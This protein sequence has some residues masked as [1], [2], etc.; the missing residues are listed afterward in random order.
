MSKTTVSWIMSNTGTISLYLNGEIYSVRS[1]H[2]NY[3]K[4]VQALKTKSYSV[5]PDLINVANAV[6]KHAERCRLSGETGVSVANGQVLYNGEVV[7][8]Y[9]ADKIVDFV[10]DGFDFAP[11]TKFLGNLMANPSKKSVDNLYRFLE[12]NDMPITEDG[13]FLAYKRVR[14]DYK[15]MYEGKFDN[16][17]GQTVKMPRNKV[18]DDP[19]ITCSHGLHVAS[20]RYARDE[21]NSGQGRLVICK[22]NP[23]DVVSVPTDYANAKMRV[24][25]YEVVQDYTEEIKQ[26]SILPRMV[27]LETATHSDFDPYDTA[28][29]DEV[30]PNCG[31]DQDDCNCDDSEACEECGYPLDECDCEE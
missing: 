18:E 5:L 14:D 28:D 27:E 15:D 6:V 16:S 11:L 2:V 26:G 22:V 31:E 9:V 17:V 30:C 7:H 19:S 12:S 10:R 23:K 29:E 24:C 8:D 1:D 4:V 3:D 21:Y 20:L 13:C 25:E